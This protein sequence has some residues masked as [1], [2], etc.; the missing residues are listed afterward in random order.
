M[1]CI[2]GGAWGSSSTFASSEVQP[3]A[4]NTCCTPTDPSTNYLKMSG[5]ADGCEVGGAGGWLAPSGLAEGTVLSQEG[6]GLK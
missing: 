1:E 4:G 2:L 3:G 6:G 5:R